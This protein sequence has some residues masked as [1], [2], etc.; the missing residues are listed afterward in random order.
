MGM[1]TNNGVCN[2]EPSGLSPEF[3]STS[4]GLQE[5]YESPYLREAQEEA[6]SVMCSH[7]GKQKSVTFS[8]QQLNRT[9]PRVNYCRLHST[10][11]QERR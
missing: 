8:Y 4:K 11:I 5:Y 3:P 6:E 2:A 1:Y 10:L 7:A 9:K